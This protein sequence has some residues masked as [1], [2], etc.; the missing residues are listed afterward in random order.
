[1]AKVGADGVRFCI[2]EGGIRKYLPQ[3]AES[4][5][6]QRVHCWDPPISSLAMVHWYKHPSS[7]LHRLRINGGVLQHG[8]KTELLYQDIDLH[9]ARQRGHLL[10]RWNSAWS[11]PHHIHRLQGPHCLNLWIY[12]QCFTQMGLHVALGANVSRRRDTMD[13]RGYP[14][15]LFNHGHG[16][17]LHPTTLPR[18][19]LCCLYHRVCEWTWKDYWIF[20]RVNI[21]SQ[22]I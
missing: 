4:Q 20:C 1:M 21:W 8:Q 13:L 9:A 11:I 22:C 17:L 10:G 7:L 14:S 2:V 12:H 15:R 5:Q 18:L 16:W 6:F 3:P 19:L